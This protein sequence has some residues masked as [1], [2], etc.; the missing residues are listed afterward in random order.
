MTLHCPLCG[1]YPRHAL[2][3]ALTEDGKSGAPFETAIAA[4]LRPRV[5]PRFD[6][7]LPTR[8]EGRWLEWGVEGPLQ[9]VGS[10]NVLA[11]K[12]GGRRVPPSQAPQGSLG[13]IGL[14][15]GRQGL[16]AANKGQ[17][18]PGRLRLV[19]AVPGKNPT[20]YRDGR[21]HVVANLLLAEGLLRLANHQT[22]W[23]MTDCYV[24][25]RHVQ[26]FRWSYPRV[27]RIYRAL[28][29]HLRRI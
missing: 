12:E 22:H 6:P 21:Q 11:Q 23:G 16:R 18:K 20:G 9:G 14:T 8:V 25:L 27:C 29:L 26:G 7:R 4:P 3:R 13:K 19:R 15:P 10:G 1:A 28:A 2:N 17:A 24:Y 5:R